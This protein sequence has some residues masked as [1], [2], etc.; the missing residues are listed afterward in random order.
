MNTQNSMIHAVVLGGFSFVFGLLLAL[1]NM[2]TA[3]DIV[4]RSQEDRQNSIGQV[5]PPDLYDNNPVHDALVVD[6][7]TIYRGIKAGKVTGLA[8][9]ISGRG[10]GGEI[11]L[12]LGI[13]T[14]GKILGIRLL[15]HQETPGLGDKINE[16]KTDWIL[17]FT[18]K[19][20][21]DPPAEKWK[22]QKDGGVFDQ[23]AGATV[24]PR[25]V[26]GAIRAGLDF[27]SANQEKLTAIK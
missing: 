20:L 16:K 21:A 4:L 9:E 3:E 7:K 19:S 27:F 18:G 12:M 11:K 14:Q 15:A 17:K 26:V 5:I 13:D 22:V 24:T 1:T 6:E 8:Y 25:A 2:L 10:Y 23:F